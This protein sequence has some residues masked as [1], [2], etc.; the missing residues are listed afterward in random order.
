MVNLDNM[1]RCNVIWSIQSIKLRWEEGLRPEAMKQKKNCPRV[2]HLY[3]LIDLD[4][5]PNRGIMT[6]YTSAEAWISLIYWI[7]TLQ[8]TRSTYTAFNGPHRSP[9]TIMDQPQVRFGTRRHEGNTMTTPSPTTQRDIVVAEGIGPP[10]RSVL[11]LV[12]KR[13]P[14]TI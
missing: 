4:E 7:D 12:T 1:C 9:A 3:G 11:M 2:H 13:R 14:S 8:L 5:S 6:I 10:R